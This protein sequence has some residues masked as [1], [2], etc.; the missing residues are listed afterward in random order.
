MT[1]DLTLLTGATGL[2][3][4]L[5]AERLIRKGRAVI[6]LSRSEH[7]PDSKLPCIRADLK[8]PGLGLSSEVRNYLQAN[9]SEIV[10]CAADTRFN[11]PLSESRETNITGTLRMLELARGCTALRKFAHIS[12]VYVAGLQAGTIPERV[13][14][15]EREFTTTYEDTKAEAEREIL[16]ESCVPAAVYRLST[17]VGDSATGAIRQLNWFHKIARLA[18]WLPGLPGEPVRNTPVDLIASDWSADVLE[19]LFHQRFEEGIVYHVCAG[20]SHSIDLPDL[21]ELLFSE[22][23]RR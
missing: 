7:R 15:E 12:T 9:V 11:A 20:E 19:F 18:Q 14:H 8:K 4:G 23:K 5:W 3:G 22:S 1:N 16:R 2:V 6:A 10:H 21:F 13:H 17:A